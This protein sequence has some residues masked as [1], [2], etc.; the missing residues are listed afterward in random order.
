MALGPGATTVVGDVEIRNLGAQ[1]DAGPPP[2]VVAPVQITRGTASTRLE[3][4]VVGYP[5]RGTVLAETALWATPREDVQV[6]L[7]RASDD[8]D[9]LVQVHVRPLAA[10]VWW[11][12]LLIATGGIAALVRLVPRA[13]RDSAPD[14][15]SPPAARTRDRADGRDL[16]HPAPAGAKI[17]AATPSASPP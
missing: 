9:V 8:G 13:R 2:R 14:V 15:T 16:E 6:A 3:P 5:A 7:R 1:T 10:L 11:G 4:S 17:P 12:A